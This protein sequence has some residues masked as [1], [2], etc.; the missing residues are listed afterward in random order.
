MPKARFIQIH[1]LHGYTGVLLNRDDS[2]MSKRM[3]FG[4]AER[5]RVSPQCLNRHWREDTGKY[6]LQN[7]VHD[8]LR[9]KQ[10]S[11][12]VIAS[13]IGA[14]VPNELALPMIEAFHNGLYGKPRPKPGQREDEDEQR[15]VQ[16]LL[17]GQPEID[18]LCE[19][20]SEI[21][22]S[23]KTPEQARQMVD[24]LFD[25]SQAE[26][27][28]SMRS[29]LIMPGGLIG[30]FH[31]RMVTSDPR[32]NITGA[33]HVAHAYTVHPQQVEVEWFTAA[34]DLNMPQYRRRFGD[35]GSPGNGGAAY[36]GET[37]ITSGLF[38]V[39][40]NIDIPTLEF[41]M[42]SDRDLLAH[43]ASHMAGLIATVSPG[44]KKG[45]T[46]P[47]GYAHELM[48]EIGDRAP[49]TLD[50]AYEKAIAFDTELA[51]GKMKD[52]LSW[53]DE[54]YGTH[55]HRMSLSTG[56]TLDGIVDW[57]RASVNAGEAL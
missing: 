57:I 52:T 4:D 35:D 7:L 8:V 56:G 44:A 32:A 20:A 19:K 50:L 34:E 39:Y 29:Q 11:D 13:A 28:S 23:A 54:K 22:M 3:T 38:Y 46:A 48:V 25:N 53:F 37:E 26:N 14:L 43:A 5:T 15:G 6:S 30:A 21:A 55:E 18:Y 10:M 33:V 1:A 27:F 49:R 47:F 16:P 9:T 17:F 12:Y 41:N 24:D 36:I 31:G 51:I 40:V 2:G 45:S 42:R